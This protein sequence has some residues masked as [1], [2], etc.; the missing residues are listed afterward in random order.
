MFFVKFFSLHFIGSSGPEVFCTNVA[1]RNFAK[2]TGKQLRQRLFFKNVAVFL[3]KSLAQVFSWD[4]CKISKNTFFIELLRWLLLFVG[5]NTSFI[6]CNLLT[7][8]ESLPRSRPE[9]FLLQQEI[10]PFD[11]C[12]FHLINGDCRNDFILNEVLF[13]PEI[14]MFRVK[15]YVEELSE[16]EVSKVSINKFTVSVCHTIQVSSLQML[17]LIFQCIISSLP[18][19]SQTIF[20]LTNNKQSI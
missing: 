8:E 10:L 20:I 5:S 9:T 17:T 19:S 11:V 16:F 13:Q 12:G 18:Y 14:S 6:Q 2:F 3:K 1:L 15:N 7:V 4:F